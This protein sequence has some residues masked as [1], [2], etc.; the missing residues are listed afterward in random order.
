MKKQVKRIMIA[1]TGSGSGKTTL[2]CGILQCFLRR[3]IVPSA[4]KCGPD[5]IDPMFHRE[6][7]GVSAGNLDGFFCDDNT[8]RYLL[9]ENT[10][11]ESIAVIE[12]VMG[13][14]DGIGMTERASSFAV[15]AA[16]ETPVVLVIGC[17]GMAASVKA[18]L[19]GYVGSEPE[20]RRRIRGVIFN[21]LPES[22]YEGAAACARELGLI[23]LGFVPQRSDIVLE[24]RHLGLVMPGETEEIDR[25]L[26]LMAD[27]LE[28]T[29]DIDG[30]LSIAEGAPWITSENIW[31]GVEKLPQALRVGV[32]KDEAFC[33]LYRDNLDFLLRAGCEL[34]Y[35][36]PLRDKELPDGI[37]LLLLCGGYPELYAAGLSKNAAMR[38]AVRAWIA[39]GRPCI[40]ECGG[41]LYL[42]EELEDSVGIVHPMACALPGRG[43]KGKRLGNFGYIG[44]T[45]QRDNLL[46][47]KGERLRAHEFHYWGCEDNG[48]A[49]RAEKA[50]DGRSWSTAEAD[51]ALYAGFPHLYFYGD[52]RRYMKVLRK[53]ET[54]YQ[55]LRDTCWSKIR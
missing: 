48:D 13:Y 27:M 2:V 34:V 31:E 24:S 44:L 35:F 47:K 43:I 6:A 52:I 23:P 10:K 40:A 25:R 26:G 11:E 22:L 46:C 12:G 42:H 32:A 28:E 29:V 3:G 15:A 7:L 50:S 53:C 5:Y 41:F 38:G 33:F 37:G 14:F 30:I 17:R 4:F 9:A 19:R 39:K 1:G 55:A 18:V 16:T 54:A 21:M 51:G 20:G 45:A 36:S 8:L 49:F